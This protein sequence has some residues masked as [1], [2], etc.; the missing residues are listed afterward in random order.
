MT[1]PL[2]YE[3]FNEIRTSLKA[4]GPGMEEY[5]LLFNLIDSKKYPIKTFDEFSFVLEKIWLKSSLHKKIFYEILE[6][7]REALIA[8]TESLTNTEIKP[9][10]SN[11]T[12]RPE[13]VTQDGISDNIQENP[14][15]KNELN[16]PVDTKNE[17]EY[18]DN[19]SQFDKNEKYGKTSFSLSGGINSTSPLLN[20]NRIE[21]KEDKLLSTPYLFTNDYM[22]VKSR[23]LQQAWRQLKNKR[24]GEISSEININKTIETV[25]KKGY[26]SRFEFSKYYTNQLHV[27]VLVDQSETMAAEEAFGEELWKAARDS[28]MHPD[29]CPLYFN[30]VPEKRS[31]SN[32]Y[33]LTNKNWTKNII[34]KNLFAN[35]IR[36]N[37]VILIY[38]DAGA[39]YDNLDMERVNQT[40][41]FISYL[42][43]NSS[44]IAWI[45]PAPKNRWSGTNAS[46]IKEEIPMF[47]NS[48][49]EIE[50]AMSALKGKL[51][52]S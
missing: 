44:Y 13:S 7:R 18:S 10:L 6:K 45:N 9:D 14:K 48:R 5:F 1:T 17:T 52:I 11:T 43:K 38:S 24:E 20:F 22:P 29:V 37:I 4:E 16:S 36:N 33:L 12:I 51:T 40:K 23:H 28:E 8:I 34:L 25:S 2:L 47:E 32:D 30:K 50:N 41:R 42:Y 21:I 31:N 46:Y 19:G 39:L 26:F 3:L 15:S 27:F 49:T 35:K